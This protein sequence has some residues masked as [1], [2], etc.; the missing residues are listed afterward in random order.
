M[1]TVCGMEENQE[2]L[3]AGN[4]L[5]PHLA[6]N[7]RSRQTGLGDWLGELRR[8]RS[9]RNYASCYSL[10]K[11]DQRNDDFSASFFLC[12][13]NTSHIS[14]N[15]KKEHLHYHCVARADLAIHSKHSKQPD[16]FKYLVLKFDK[17]AN[18]H[19]GSRLKNQKPQ[20][21]LKAATVFQE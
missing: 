11:N 13:Q 14:W 5:E 2:K 20:R 21:I 10:F 6:Q 7:L 17:R 1:E 4:E 8:L 19:G 3:E 9:L 15:F 18:Y 16:S 12:K